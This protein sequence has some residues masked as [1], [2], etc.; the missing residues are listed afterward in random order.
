MVIT[1]LIFIVTICRVEVLQSRC[2]H[3]QAETFC[4][5][6]LKTKSGALLKKSLEEVRYILF[7]TSVRLGPLHP[8]HEVVSRDTCDARTRFTIGHEHKAHVPK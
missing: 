2:N 6:L 8:Q 1:E 7:R 5:S 3:Y 4:L